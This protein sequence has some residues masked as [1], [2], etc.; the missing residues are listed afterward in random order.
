MSIRNHR[1]ISRLLVLSLLVLTIQKLYAQEQSDNLLSFRQLE[2]VSPWFISG[3]AAGLSQTEDIFPAML[4]MAFNQASGDFHDILSGDTKN[5]YEFS[6]QSF[7]NL[8]RTLL[9]GSFAYHKSFEK[10]L[11]FSDVNDPSV[12]YPYL[13]VDTVGHGTYNREFFGLNGAISSPVSERLDWG[14]SFGLEVG[15]ASQNRDPRPDNKVVKTSISPGLLYKNNHWTVGT[16]LRY[17]YY[18][19]DI[20]V[21]VVEE[22]GQAIMFQLHGPGVY[23]YHVSGSFARLYKQSEFGYGLQAGWSSGNISNLFFSDVFNSRQTVDDGRKGSIATW[24]AVKNDARLEQ[25]HWNLKN[26]F[27]VT[28]DKNI[29]QLVAGYGLQTYLGTEFIQLLEK[30]NET[31]V[32]KW[33]TYGEEQKYYSLQTKAEL[34]YRLIS[35]N[36]QNRMKS[37]IDAAVKYQFFREKY[38]LPDW[39]QQYANLRLACSFLKLFQ[40]SRQ[41]L[42]LEMKAVVQFNLDRNQ[43]LD[44]NLLF[45]RIFRPEMDYLTENYLSP[46]VS[47]GYEVPLKKL[48]GKFFVKAD[49]DWVRASN[50]ATRTGFGFSTGLMF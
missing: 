11:I 44:N 36:D 47:L 29:H 17:T 27:S 43:N 49:F 50:G 15:E 21:L 24:S 3:N 22:G 20:D 5:S 19:E 48:F 46:G 42:S 14:L 32:E 13:L 41:S 39:D 37:L 6:S 30:V 16:N 33:V 40:F 4:G 31:D 7:R 2:I 12:N 25:L 34:N 8:G 23:G 9:Y 45:E 26:V 1:H 35:K 28:K 18:N 10:E 38:Y